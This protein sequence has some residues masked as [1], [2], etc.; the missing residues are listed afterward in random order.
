[1]DDKSQAAIPD[2]FGKFDAKR[3]ELQR[4]M[5]YY[6]CAMMEIETKFK[7]LNEERLSVW[8]RNPIENIKCRVKSPESIFEKL[9][10]RGLPLTISSI[11]EN[12]TD[13][14]GVRVICE[15]IEDVYELAEV[16]LAQDDI[17]L[18]ERKDYIQNP[19]P[20]GYRSLHLIVQT[21][22]FLLDGRKDMKVEIQ[23]RTIAMDFWAS[24]EHDLNYKK[25]YHLPQEISKEL[26][27]CAE[28]SA[29]L[30]KRMNALKCKVLDER[31][32]TGKNSELITILENL[33][34]YREAN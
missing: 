31:K 21:P 3:Q 26:L 5:S 10:R 15:F 33:I 12:L 4:L 13:V 6:R 1:M 11:E 27:A 30:D 23:F 22:I 14:A 24:L 8:E 34:K 28:L 17:E 32:G 20:N 29:S 25:G 16:L 9:V 19:K 2:I 18:I 7:V